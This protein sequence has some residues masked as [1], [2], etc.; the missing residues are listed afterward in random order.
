MD[1]QK[2]QTEVR[3]TPES[4][5]WARWLRQIPVT[6]PQALLLAVVS[7]DRNSAAGTCKSRGSMLGGLVHR[8]WYATLWRNLKIR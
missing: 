3:K 8:L 2:E 7:G 4:S 5:S 1:A 6:L